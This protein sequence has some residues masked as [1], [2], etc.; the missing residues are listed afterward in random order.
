MDLVNLF[1]YKN[2]ETK[3][4]KLKQVKDLFKSKEN[5]DK[6]SHILYREL[7]LPNNQTI[8]NE[9]KNKVNE[10]IEVWIKVGKL[11]KLEETVG[12]SIN[13]IDEQL[14]Y[15]NEVEGIPLVEAEVKSKRKYVKSGK[16]SKKKSEELIKEEP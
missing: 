7:Y 10:Y 12:Y 5:K 1:I 13:A 15:Y 16:Y 4:V 6:L 11:D 8:F 2:L 3:N 14:N 9:I